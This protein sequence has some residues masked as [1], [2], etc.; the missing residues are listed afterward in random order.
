VL[1]WDGQGD[2]S[3]VLDG[4]GYGSHG[5]FY[6]QA[7]CVEEGGKRVI[8]LSGKSAYIWPLSSPHL[9]LAPPMTL[10]IRLKPEAP[11]NLVFWDFIYCLTG[12]GPEF[13]VGYQPNTLFG[14]PRGLSDTLTSSGPFLQAG[15]WQTLAIVAADQQV[16]LYCD[17]QLVESLAAPLKAG[18]WGPLVM[19]DGQGVH[20]RLSF[21]GS[22]PGDALML[23]SDEIPPTGGGIR[24]RVSH[25]AIYRRAL[26]ENEIGGFLPTSSDSVR[27]PAPSKPAASVVP[28]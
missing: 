24:G 14:K 27:K 11:G 22:G 26:S 23:A 3:G 13:G 2:A 4:S 8:E 5:K 15:K 25:L 21:F 7:A 17:G 18:N 10:V 6:D 19:D 9:T 12:S 16:K 20:R 28:R 1:R